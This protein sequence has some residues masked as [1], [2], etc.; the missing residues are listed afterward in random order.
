MAAS[1]EVRLLTPSG[2]TLDVIDEWISLSYNRT[3]NNVGT[4]TL[5][6]PGDYPYYNL[7]LDGFNVIGWSKA[8]MSYRVVSDLNEGEL[9]ELQ[10]LL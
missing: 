9:R 7:K 3:L 4:L 5:E 8:G 6:L 2:D 10:S 1:Y